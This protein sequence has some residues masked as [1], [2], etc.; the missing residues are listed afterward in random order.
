ADSCF[1]RTLRLFY[2][3]FAYLEVTESSESPDRLISYRVTSPSRVIIED[4]KESFGLFDR[5]GDS[6]VGYNQVPDI[7]RA[8]GQ[9]FTHQQDVHQD[10]GSHSAAVE[11]TDKPPDTE[12]SQVQ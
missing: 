11:T 10:S 1:P 7:M 9:H 2:F 3:P 6:Q 5:I 8:L 4:F 12:L